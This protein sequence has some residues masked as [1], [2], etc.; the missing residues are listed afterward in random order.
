[1]HT[2]HLAPFERLASGTAIQLQPEVSNQR[3]FSLG[4]P[5]RGAP[6]IA[7]ARR[8]AQTNFTHTTHPDALR[9]AGGNL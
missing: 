1:M 2:R 9:L 4:Y 8:S 5:I 7:F 6:C 3:C